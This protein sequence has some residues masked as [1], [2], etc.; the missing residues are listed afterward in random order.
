MYIRVGRS[1]VEFYACKEHGKWVI[2]AL[3]TAQ[4]AGMEAAK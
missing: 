2:D 4:M 3:R 1:N